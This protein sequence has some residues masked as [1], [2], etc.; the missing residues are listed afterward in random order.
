M[1]MTVKADW[2][3]ICLAILFLIKATYLAFLVT[4]LWDVPD[5]IGHYAYAEDL[6]YGRGIPL[7][8]EAKISSEINSN[9]F[10]VPRSASDN[11]I[12]QHPPAYYILAAIPIK[13]VS[14]FSDSQE[15]RFRAP[16]IVTAIAGGLAI[17]VLYQTLKFLSLGRVFA[18]AMASAIGFVPMFSHM[19]SG[20]SHD[21]PL[22]LFSALAAHSFAKYIIGRQVLDAYICAIW[23]AIAVSTKITALVLLAPVLAILIFE[24]DGPIGRIIKHATGI[25]LTALALPGLWF[26][27]NIWYFHNPFATSVGQVPVPVGTKPSFW[28]FMQDNPVIEHFVLNFFG[29]FG[30]IGTGNGEVAWFQIHGVPLLGFSLIYLGVASIMAVGASIY[31][32]S[33]PLSALPT[34]GAP[35]INYF[36]V[37]YDVTVKGRRQ[38]FATAIAASLIMLSLVLI[39]KS[40][41]QNMNYIRSVASVFLVFAAAV[42]LFIIISGRQSEQK[43]LFAYCVLIFG[44]FAF[45]LVREI[46]SVSN[47]LG[48]MRAT[49]GR[50]IYPVAP[51]VILAVGIL[52]TRSKMI[53]Y[54]SVAAVAS[55]AI[56]GFLTFAT[57]VIPFYTPDVDR[58]LDASRI[59]NNTP[60][61]ELTKGVSVEQTF[62]LSTDEEIAI[63]G[64]GTACVQLYSATYNRGNSG[65]ANVSISAPSW[66]FSGTLD[67]SG[68]RDNSFATVCG[69]VEH[70]PT[71][72]TPPTIHIRGLEG[73]TGTSIT[74]WLTDDTSNG[75]AVING[76]ESGKSLIFSIGAASDPSLRFEQQAVLGIIYLIATIV[77]LIVA[78]SRPGGVFFAQSKIDGA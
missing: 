28:Q 72:H 20:T 2:P 7:L 49:H 26:A 50:Y 63:S 38:F 48:Q 52:V 12:A 1:K 40:Q 9:V 60:A 3:I 69:P 8:G 27:R 54:A 35:L 18:T 14:W 71:R 53:G 77:L 19:A 24:L 21:V 67:Y 33:R 64:Q 78:R 22:F 36:W 17:I 66:N 61:G 42:S 31:L 10:G 56:L 45:I 76:Q 16:R 62:T 73:E 23:L 11:W 70:H 13:V 44:F 30:W 4:P 68:A 25:T 15:L 74:A 59:V 29:L 58:I 46:Y 6:A 75:T 5:E 65:M 47:I 34:S 32:F 41:P 43:R 51:M 39:Y 55:M 37:A 57:Q